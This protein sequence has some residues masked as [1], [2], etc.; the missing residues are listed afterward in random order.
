LLSSFTELMRKLMLAALVLFIAMAPHPA[1]AQ[2]EQSGFSDA[3]KRALLDPTTYA[4]AIVSYESQRLDWDSSQAFFRHGITEHNPQFTISGFPD[5]Q[6]ISYGAGNAKILRTSLAVLGASAANNVTDRL[7]ES[8]LVRRYPNHRKLVHA[9]GWVE[10]IGVAS[11]LS[12]QSSVLHFQQWQTN[13]QVA[14]QLGY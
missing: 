12:Y 14:A 11:Y 8:T 9:I 7:F 6:P 13:R 10:R 4:P 3:L 5:G 2:E 1:R